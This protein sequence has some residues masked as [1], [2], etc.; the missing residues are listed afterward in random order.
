MTDDFDIEGLFTGLNPEQAREVASEMVQAARQKLTAIKNPQPQDPLQQQEADELE[1]LRQSGI[2]G[3]SFATAKRNI[4]QKYSNL[5]S[6][7]PAPVDEEIEAIKGNPRELKKLYEDRLAKISRSDKARA[8]KLH[9][10]AELRA[11]F[12]RAGLTEE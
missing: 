1:R 3:T 5:R 11:Q 4:T 2:R 8:T 6:Q 9:E 12:K 10:G 7:K